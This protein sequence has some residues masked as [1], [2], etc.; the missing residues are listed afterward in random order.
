MFPDFDDDTLASVLA[1]CGSDINLAAELCLS[2]SQEAATAPGG[3]GGGGGGDSMADNLALQGDEAVAV[4]LANDEELARQLQEQLLM[5]DQQER[6]QRAEQ[7]RLQQMHSQ[8]QNYP[9]AGSGGALYRPS[10]WGANSPPPGQHTG[11]DQGGTMSEALYSAG[12]SVAAGASSLWSWAMGDDGGTGQRKRRDDA[13]EDAAAAVEEHEMQP[14]R[15][16]ARRDDQGGGYSDVGGGY[17]GSYGSGTG[18]GGLGSRGDGSFGRAHSAGPPSAG[19]PP[20][21]V[22]RDPL[23][24]GALDDDPADVNLD[25]PLA[26]GAIRDIG[27]GEDG[28]DEVSIVQASSSLGGASGGEVRRRGARQSAGGSDLI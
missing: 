7:V 3:G 21:R 11:A 10:Q 26:A 2:M 5:Q 14:M 24:R 23:E 16:A 6:Q 20:P 12:S 13:D 19:P 18:G 9:G 17:S 22:S 1:S 8:Q 25:D 4:Q 15:R 28:R 27:G